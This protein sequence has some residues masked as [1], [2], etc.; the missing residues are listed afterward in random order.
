MSNKYQEMTGGRADD[1]EADRDQRFPVYNGAVIAL[2]KPEKVIAYGTALKNKNLE[3][4]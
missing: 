1:L 3:K 2:E 4:Q